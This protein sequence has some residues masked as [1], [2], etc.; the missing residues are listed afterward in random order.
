MS[1]FPLVQIIGPTNGPVNVE[2]HAGVASIYTVPGNHFLEW[3]HFDADN[4]GA[5]TACMLVD[6]SD[7]VNW[8]H[9]ETGFVHLSYVK[10]MVN[11]DTNFTGDIKLGFLSAVDA[12]N[13][14]LNILHNI[15]MEQDKVTLVETIDVI[16]SQI[17]CELAHWFGPTDADVALFQTDVN[18]LGPDGTTA[19]PSGDGDL[20]LRIEQTAG[21]VDV[22]V[23]IGYTTHA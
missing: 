11:P 7:N 14:D 9:T 19:F 3:V 20:V 2:N 8:P 12:D 23:D 22:G 13:G 1:Y 17:H 6:L 15:H 16:R 10:I 18:L 4:I 5:D 21:N